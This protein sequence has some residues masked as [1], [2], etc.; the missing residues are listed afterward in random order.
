VSAISSPRSSCD[1]FSTIASPSSS[2]ASLSDEVLDL[3]DHRGQIVL[4]QFPI[5]DEQTGDAML[6]EQFA[7]GRRLPLSLI[8]IEP[9]V[10]LA[11]YFD[12]LVS[13]GQIK[14]HGIQAV[15]DP[16]F[17]F[18]LD[19][20]TSQKIDHQPLRPGFTPL[21]EHDSLETLLRA[22]C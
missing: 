21:R 11:V 14:I 17:A 13:L 2:P 3:P 7:L 16:L 20:Q 15:T 12:S 5:P 22:C 10:Y 8:R 1:F 6:L 19:L 18:E 4:K 9:G